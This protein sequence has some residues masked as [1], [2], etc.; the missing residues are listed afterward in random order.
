MRTL[1]FPV[2]GL[3]HFNQT[4]LELVGYAGY[5]VAFSFNTGVTKLGEFN[6]YAIPCSGAP[7]DFESFNALF[8]FPHLMDY[9]AAKR[10]ELQRVR[11]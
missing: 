7:S 4:S 9:D 8:H 3:E 1:A 6:R 11:A 5:D 10:R 2:G